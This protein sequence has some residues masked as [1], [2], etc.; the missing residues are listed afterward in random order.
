LQFD[1]E[2]VFVFDGDDV[3]E[4]DIKILFSFL[5]TKFFFIFYIFWFV[6]LNNG[7]VNQN[8]PYEL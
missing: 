8:A 2:S 4:R 6:R 7:G 1:L 3:V 5:K